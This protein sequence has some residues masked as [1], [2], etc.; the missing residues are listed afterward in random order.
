MLR[1]GVSLKGIFTESWGT[2]G[3]EGD[4]SG[5]VGVPAGVLRVSAGVR[6]RPRGP[7]SLLLTP[8]SSPGAT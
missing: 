7:G 1:C 6:D 8:G 3:G 4:S 5:W 2:S